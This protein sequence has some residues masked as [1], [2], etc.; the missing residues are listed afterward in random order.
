MMFLQQKH[1]LG[2]VNGR[3]HTVE[4]ILISVVIEKGLC[5]SVTTFECGIVDELMYD[6]DQYGM[7]DGLS[8]N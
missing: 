5:E 4:I 2:H 1:L 6:M 3:Y 8:M 7:L